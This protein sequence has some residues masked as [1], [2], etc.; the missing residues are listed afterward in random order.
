MTRSLGD[1]YLKPLVIPNPEL[2]TEL[3]NSNTEGESAD[4]GA[5]LVLASDG[6]WDAISSKE[7]G[8]VVLHCLKSVPEADVESAVR[9]SSLALVCGAQQRGSTDNIAVLVAHVP[10]A[11]AAA[12]TAASGNTGAEKAAPAAEYR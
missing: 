10:K 5:V 1:T 6:L 3:L 11:T 9:L 2:R 8:E 7:A 4:F 12:V